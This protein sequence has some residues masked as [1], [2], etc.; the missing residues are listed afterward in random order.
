MGVDDDECAFRI[1]GPV[2]VRSDVGVVTFARRQQRDLLALL[3]LR[4][5]QVLP[6][7][8]IVDAMWGADVPRTA[9]TQVKNMASGLRTALTDGPRPLAT[10]EWLPAGYRLR[11]HRGRLDLALFT[12][13]VGEARVVGP[14][15]SATLLRRAVDLWKGRQA[16][17]GVRARFADDARRQLHEQ[18]TRA[19]EELFDAELAGPDHGSVIAELTAAVAE[20]PTRER[21]V[22]QLMVALYRGGRTCD[23]LEVYQRARRVLVDDYAI[24][25]GTALREL[26]HQILV[27]DPALEVPS[28][29]GPALTVAGPPPPR[30]AQLPLDVRGF[31]G[32]ARELHALD[33]M[34]DDPEQART[35]VISALM[36]SAGIGKTALA[37]HWAHRVAHRFPDGQMYVNLRGFAADTTP[38]APAEAIR[39]FLDAFAIPP[40]RIPL[41][42]SGQVG[43]YRS[44]MAGRRMLVVLDNAVNADQVRPLL[45]GAAGCLVL[46][47]SRNQLTSLIVNEGAYPMT[48]AQLTDPEARDLL[49][50]RL[51][52]DRVGADE[53]AAR[54]IA[55]RCAGLPLALAMV[56]ASAAIQADLPLDTMAGQLADPSPLIALSRADPGSD[57]R[58]VFSWS[59]ERLHPAAAGLFRGLGLHRGPDIARSSAASVAGLPE[60]E[61]AALFTELTDAHLVLESTSGRFVLHDLLRAYAAELSAGVDPAPVRAAALRRLTDHYLHIA[62]RAASHIYPHRYRLHL[63]TPA[64]GVLVDEIADSG[65]ALA[66]FARERRNLLAAVDGAASAGLADVSW[67][68]ATTIGIF[69][70]RQGHWH[71]WI[72]ALRVA[73]E[74][75]Q[76]HGLVLGI[77]HAHSGLG[78][79]RTRMRQFD[80]AYDHLVEALDR[81]EALADPLAQAYTHLRL[82][83][84]WDGRGQPAEALAASQ[85]ARLLF[86]RVDHPAGLAQALNNLGW[87]H[88]RQGDHREAVRQC[89]A[90]VALH[91]D[92]GDRQGTAHSLDSLGYAHHQLGDYGRAVTHY[93]ES[94]LILRETGDRT[95]EAYALDHLGDALR[96]EGAARPAGEAWAAALLIFNELGHPEAD[97]V[98]LKLRR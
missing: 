41:D 71:D 72:D 96:A 35:V 93:Q 59:Y 97:S 20:H 45:P 70:D 92:L 50:A 98:R 6:V 5:D 10:V 22:G 27:G 23:A 74:T 75:A 90:A 29:L 4:A 19:Y 58:A 30:P 2:E 40:A 69:I 16:L 56:A 77:A 95:N 87:Y 18:R 31:V 33:A 82:S 47:T 32:R 61:A 81:F 25:P 79:A 94:A 42:L 39:G 80:V 7:D 67:Q 48:L 66:W 3:L 15:R 78:L 11:I 65:Q 12:D 52:R 53:T 44:L 64:P 8:H 49:V 54:R 38:M 46:V 63:T 73:L 62:D 60:A 21:L 85:R 88:A 83:A 84:V 55:A 76:R 51:G 24:E 91:R 37:L 57:L 14:A 17:A 26:E 9:A 89:E 34:L 43:L 28:P 36:G 68:L 1:L 86:E 13:L